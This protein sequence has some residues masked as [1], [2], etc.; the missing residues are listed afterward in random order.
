M[1]DDQADKGWARCLH[2][3][4]VVRALAVAQV[5]QSINVCAR[6]CSHLSDTH[7]C[8]AL[9]ARSGARLN[10]HC[11]WSMLLRT[12][13]ICVPTIDANL[14]VVQQLLVVGESDTMIKKVDCLLG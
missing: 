3:N 12:A 5:S 9:R 8:F 10:A 7:M 2:V 1:I 11:R 6:A 14:D 4:G 13:R